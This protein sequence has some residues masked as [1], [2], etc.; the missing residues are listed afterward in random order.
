[1]AKEI[2]DAIKDAELKSSEAVKLAKEAADTLISE[3]KR[4]TS[5]EFEKKVEEMSA[6]RD[7]AV[8][9]AEKKAQDMVDEACRKAKEDIASLKN[10]VT[11]KE[12]EAIDSILSELL[13]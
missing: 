12:N 6:K 10:S 5:E 2:I 13:S 9:E 8:A 4:L 11:S 3:T 1:M 7:A